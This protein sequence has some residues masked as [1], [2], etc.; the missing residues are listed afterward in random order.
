M[1]VHTYAFRRFG[2]EPTEENCNNNDYTNM[3]KLSLWRCFSRLLP[4]VFIALLPT[5][6]QIA[7][8]IDALENPE[9]PTLEAAARESA[10]RVST[11]STQAPPST[12]RDSSSTSQLGL[13]LMS[14]ASGKSQQRS[15]HS[16]GGRSDAQPPLSQ[17]EEGEGETVSNPVAV[18]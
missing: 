16:S 10:A 18:V 2:V 9:E 4:I 3:W 12:A 6:Q 15:E 11:A 14:G 5:E 8:A 1:Y 13:G 7:D 17:G